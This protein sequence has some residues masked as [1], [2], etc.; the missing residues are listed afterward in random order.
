MNLRSRAGSPCQG[1]AAIDRSPQQRGRFRSGLRRQTLAVGAS[2]ALALAAAGCAGTGTGSSAAGTTPVVGGT[3]T[4][5][6]QPSD[7][8]N[9]IFPF[10]SSAYIS[11]SNLNLFQYLLYRPLYYFGSGAQ[12][13]VNTLKSL[14]NLPVWSNGGKTVTI[15]LKHFMW[16]NGTPVTAQNIEFWLNM[17]Q[18]VGDV[19][20]GAYTRLPT[21][22]RTSMKAASSTQ[23][24]LTLNKA[25]NQ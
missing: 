13:T 2:V 20:Y 7:T 19:D 8:P 14:A 1:V 5:A 11:V 9:Y 24:V 4:F 22:Q 17:E 15:T 16:S 23:L 21:D 10:T 3:A 25:Y 6:E 18:A 12:P